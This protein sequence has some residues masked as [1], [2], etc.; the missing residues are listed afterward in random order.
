MHA[1]LRHEAEADPGSAAREVALA[2][3]DHDLDSRYA[4]AHRGALRALDSPRYFSLLDDLDRMVD[5][6][7]LT[8]R[9]T[10]PAGRDLPRLAR[11]AFRAVRRRH[12]AAEAAPTPEEREKGLHEVRKA[13]KRARYAG[14]ALQPAFGK[15]AKRFAAAMERIQEILGDHHDGVVTQQTLIAMAAQA[16]TAGENAFELGRLA[17]REEA[18]V[19]RAEDEYRR[20]WTAAS[21]KKLRRW[22]R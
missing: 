4:K 1:R 16:H 2:R 9:A 14:E 8:S 7:P 20:A 10:G 12:D 18:R 19:V 11:K 15:D 3:I 5:E 6:P 13:A 17:G 21:K 22:T